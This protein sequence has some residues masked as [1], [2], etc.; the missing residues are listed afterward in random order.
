MTSLRIWRWA[1]VRLKPR[2][3]RSGA[4]SEANASLVRE[5]LPLP[6]GTGPCIQPRSEWRRIAPMAEVS[7]APFLDAILGF[8]KTAALKA[9][10]AL[11]LFTVV[12]QESGDLDWIAARTGASARGIRILCDYLT[13][14]GFL[15]KTQDRYGLTPATQAF[16][17]TTSPAWLGSVVEFLAAPEMISLWLDDPVSYVRNGGAAGL[18]SIAPE[19]PVWVKFARAMGPFM[20]P[21]A[22]AMADVV[23][24]WPTPPKRVLDIAAGHGIFGIT[25]AQAIPSAEI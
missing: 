4:V 7:P 12:H 17:T 24:G 13:V 14:Q 3:T 19:N 5:P 21:A 2:G 6:F 11:D 22:Q 20:R 23:Q 10:L 9:A 18:G 8:Q 15:T 25:I 1:L 16:L